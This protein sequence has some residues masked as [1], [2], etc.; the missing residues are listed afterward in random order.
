MQ[1]Y[2]NNSKTLSSKRLTEHTASYIADE[3]SPLIL[4][5]YVSAALYDYKIALT[6]EKKANPSMIQRMHA[7]KM[8]FNNKSIIASECNCKASHKTKECFVII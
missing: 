3:T 1:K 2:A 7:T 6:I 4:D 8:H 5:S